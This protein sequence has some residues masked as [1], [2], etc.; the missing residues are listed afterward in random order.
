MDSAQP[1]QQQQQQRLMT[2]LAPLP[3]SPPSSSQQGDLRD[4][5]GEGCWGFDAEMTEGEGALI[6]RPDSSGTWL[7]GVGDD[8]GEHGKED[9]WKRTGIGT[10]YMVSVFGG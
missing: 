4:V 6:A 9:L 3:W 5:N 10:G 7:F 8:E 2:P 1:Q